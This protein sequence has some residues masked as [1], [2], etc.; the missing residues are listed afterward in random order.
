MKHFTIFLIILLMSVFSAMAQN[1]W[2]TP[3]EIYH[4]YG[5]QYSKTDSAF[6]Y[7]GYYYLA[8]A[9]SLYIHLPS[10]RT[11]GL[12][13]IWGY[14]TPLDSLIPVLYGKTGDTTTFSNKDTVFIALGPH[15]GNGRTMDTNISHTWTAVDTVQCN[16]AQT[17]PF[18]IYLP[19]WDALLEKPSI[20]YTLFLR[21][22]KGNAGQIY[23]KVEWI[24]A[25]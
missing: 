21:G 13:K 23:V 15:H 5:H 20:Y 7:G 4:D 8:G 18:E 14:V 3:A 17:R 25:Y 12:L 19:Q 11:N 22:T 24:T 6:Y 2:K 1:V 9:E 16:T 10:L